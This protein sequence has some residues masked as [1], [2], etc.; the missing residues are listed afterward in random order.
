MRPFLL[1]FLI[2]AHASF[3]LLPETLFLTVNILD[4]YC[5][6]RVVYR[7]H[8]QLVG[9]TALLIAS[10]Y[11][12]PGKK[13][14]R[15]RELA[16]MCCHLYEE[17]M[18][19]QM[20]RHVMVTLDWVM[21]PPTVDCFLRVALDDEEYIPEVEHMARYIAEMA[22]FHKEFVSTRPSELAKASLALTR[23][24]FNLPQP[25]KDDWACSYESI[26]LVSLS[27]NIHHP[28]QILA[29]KYSSS[30]LSR[31]ALH[32]EEFLIA[33]AAASNQA[34]P[35]TPPAEQSK[36]S[37]KAASG[38][39]TFETP[40]KHNPYPPNMPHGCLTPPITPDDGC[41]GRVYQPTNNLDGLAR[42]CPGT[43][44]PLKSQPVHMYPVSYYQPAAIM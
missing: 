25:H 5:S 33:H 4:R 42:D 19:T 29:Q 40:Q 24:I 35:P 2:E 13:V 17:D 27:Q 31:V 23:V 7:K 10:K 26:T 1:D 12:E 30:H 41:F 21:G 36:M 18:F 3:G 32:L 20:E 43:P 9:C 44:T 15:I 14:P 11:G 16:N 6:K 38:N 34:T 28:S 8:Y 39:S 37:E 22:L